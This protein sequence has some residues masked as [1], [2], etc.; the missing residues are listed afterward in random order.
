LHQQRGQQNFHTSTFQSNQASASFTSNRSNL[1]ATHQQKI[2]QGPG[3]I[4]KLLLYVYQS[5][6]SY[7]KN[8]SFKQTTFLVDTDS[9]ISLIHEMF[10]ENKNLPKV[11]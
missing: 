2:Y 9:D 1:G 4:Q 10:I 11:D 8:I 7:L 3:G 5:T 6:Q